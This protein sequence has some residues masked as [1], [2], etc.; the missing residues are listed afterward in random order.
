VPGG[1]TPLAPFYLLFCTCSPEFDKLAT[2]IEVLDR[3]KR[4]GRPT[5]EPRRRRQGAGARGRT[6]RGAQ[7]VPTGLSPEQ[8]R[9]N[10]QVWNETILPFL[11][12][13]S[14]NQDLAERLSREYHAKFPE[15]TEFMPWLHTQPEWKA[16]KSGE[17]QETKRPRE[18]PTQWA[19]DESELLRQVQEHNRQ[20]AERIAPEILAKI[21]GVEIKEEPVA[22]LV[23]PV[24]EARQIWEENIAPILGFAADYPDESERIHEAYSK[25]YPG[26]QAP[27]HFL[28]VRALRSPVA[29]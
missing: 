27:G 8:E 5:S 2:M 23:T 15:G 1:D 22:V 6:R 11:E 13:A 21:E 4:S 26:A 3:E 17:R 14:D 16:W 20:V 29:V 19:E 10:K 7:A 28:Q 12:F 9:V 18:S 24:S 25:A